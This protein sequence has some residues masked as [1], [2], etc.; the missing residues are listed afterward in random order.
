MPCGEH[1]FPIKNPMKYFKTSNGWKAFHNQ[2]VCTWRIF[3]HLFFF[4]V[5]LFG[6]F[7]YF[8]FLRELKLNI[9]TKK[10]NAATQNISQVQNIMKPPHR[11]TKDFRKPN[12][13]SLVGGVFQYFIFF[14]QPSQSTLLCCIYDAK[15]YISFKYDNPGKKGCR[16]WEDER[17]YW[18][19][20]YNNKY[21]IF[22]QPAF[23][24]WTVAVESH[25]DSSFFWGYLITQIPGGFIASKF[26]ANKIFGLSI[27]SSAFLHLFVPYAMTLMH[28][29]VVICVRVI[30]GLFEVRLGLNRKDYK[31]GFSIYLEKKLFKSKEL[32]MFCALR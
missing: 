13:S 17:F 2:F 22:S 29:H 30:Q 11:S 1:I 21:N 25:V 15:Y 16:G 3:F 5:G 28:G 27:V 23:L 32:K 9:S 12:K 31:G 14:I 6:L 10:I 7:D 4:C 26:P 19:G 18:N 20:F 24:N 8:W